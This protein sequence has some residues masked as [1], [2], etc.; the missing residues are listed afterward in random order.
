MKQ[1][2]IV[3][4]LV[5]MF[6]GVAMAGTPTNPDDFQTILSSAPSVKTGLAWDMAKDY[7]DLVSLSELEIISYKGFSGNLGLAT[8]VNDQAHGIFAGGINYNLGT[9]AKYGINVPYGNSVEIGA[10]ASR[11]F[12]NKIWGFG[13]VVLATKKF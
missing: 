2:V 1:L 5:L 3:S 7:N 4:V 13:P 8:S 11:D 10:Y 12:S 6:C 9:L